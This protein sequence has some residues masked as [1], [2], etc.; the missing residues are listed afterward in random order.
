MHFDPRTIEEHTG[1][2]P[3]M[4]STPYSVKLLSSLLWTEAFRNTRNCSK[5]WSTGKVHSF[6]QRFSGVQKSRRFLHGTKPTQSLRLKSVPQSEFKAWTYI[7]KISEFQIEQE[8]SHTHT[9]TH[10]QTHKVLIC[11]SLSSEQ[12]LNSMY[13]ITTLNR[14]EVTEPQDSLVHSMISHSL[15]VR[16][17]F[18]DLCIPKE[19]IYSLNV[20]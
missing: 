15:N 18:M 7:L 14:Q 1:C 11:C 20:I 10:I 17:S 3:W 9:D 13:W 16:F 12:F 2:T 4:L 6:P 5:P 19:W 8:K